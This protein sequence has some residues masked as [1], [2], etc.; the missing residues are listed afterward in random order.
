MHSYLFIGNDTTSRIRAM[1]KQLEERTISP[2]DQVRPMGTQRSVGI[3]EIRVFLRALSLSPQQSPSV[4]G[5]I[6]QAD[7]LSLE[8]QAALL[9]TLEEP[10]SQ[11][12]ILL[13]APTSDALL[14]TIVS[15]CIIVRLTDIGSEDTTI[16]INL[17]SSPGKLL[18]D[19][20]R[21]GKTKEEYALIF[22]Q[23]ISA[24]RAHHH[25]TL[26]HR[27]L[28]ARQYISNNVHPLLL[29]EHILL[30]KANP[31]RYNKF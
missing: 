3:A 28:R 5:V 30:D 24:L 16:P 8:A 29:L 9:K 20:S 19:L 12:Y 27:L 17:E 26:L 15:R 21:L 14:P 1:D 6:E 11:A 22:D 4:A 10:P 31:I 18:A 23:L 7:H 13:G 2:F 25:T